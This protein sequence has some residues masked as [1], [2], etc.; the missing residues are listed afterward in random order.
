ML[1]MS[2]IQAY[3]LIIEHKEHVSPDKV[4]SWIETIITKAVNRRGGRRNTCRNLLIYGKYLLL[5]TIFQK[6]Q[7]DFNGI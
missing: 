1:N 7:I 5:I 2:D 3:K 6:A 4:R